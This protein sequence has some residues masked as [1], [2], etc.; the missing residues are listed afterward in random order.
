MEVDV[1]VDAL[2][3]FAHLGGLALSV[4]KVST[5]CWKR[6]GFVLAL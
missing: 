2:A 5:G 4:T 3:V 6:G 1:T